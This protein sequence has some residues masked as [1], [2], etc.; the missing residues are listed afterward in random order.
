MLGTLVYTQLCTGILLGLHYTP[1]IPAAYYSVMHIYREVYYGSVYRLLHSGGASLV[2]LL[3]LAHVYR[4]VF[5]GSYMYV[6]GVLAGGQGVYGVLMAIAFMGY[7]LPWGTMSYWGATVITNLYTGV[8][9]MVPWSLGGFCITS[10]GLPRYSI[11]HSILPLPAPLSLVL[12]VLYVHRVS[13][14][15]GPGYGTNSRVHFHAWLVPKDT[16]VVV[17]GVP[18]AW[19]QVYQGTIM[20]AHPDNS[21][22]SSVVL[23]PL[24]IVPE[25]YYLGYY[26]VLKAVPGRA[27]GFL[28]MVS[29][30]LG[31]GIHGEPYSTSPLVGYGSPRGRYTV[32]FLLSLVVL[33]SLWVGVQLP[34]GR[35]LG[36]G[37]GSM[38][39]SWGCN[40]GYTHRA[41]YPL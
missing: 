25:W 16:G 15:G 3:V 36:Q 35:Y 40:T 21:L 22:P 30:T 20:L 10:P 38:L 7:V 37:R 13:T 4:G 24:H 19:V 6:S 2:F 32:V 14:G 33:Y 11:I 27:S 39:V 18:G 23:T 28:V 41:P 12:H 34:R 5:Y 29:C 31:A 8:P 1:G 26:G 9:C 17:Q